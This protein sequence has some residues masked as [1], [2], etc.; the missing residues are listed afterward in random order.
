MIPEFEWPKTDQT[1]RPLA[2]S[3]LYQVYIPGEE[4]RAGGLRALGQVLAELGSGVDTVDIGA[5]AA[6]TPIAVWG[7]AAVA[8]GAVEDLAAVV[9][10]ENFLQVQEHRD[11]YP[12]RLNMAADFPEALHPATT[13]VTFVSRKH[14]LRSSL[15]LTV[16]WST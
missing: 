4:R 6:V 1:A 7:F 3:L 13:N 12:D 8:A 11:P 9:A 10:G 14:R 2:T 16:S 5:A 15:H